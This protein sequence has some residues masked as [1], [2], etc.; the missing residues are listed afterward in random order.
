MTCKNC[1]NRIVRAETPDP[2]YYHPDT[3]M[4]WCYDPSDSEIEL[5]RRHLRAEPS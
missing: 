4:V 3:Q 1:G 5:D 2:Y